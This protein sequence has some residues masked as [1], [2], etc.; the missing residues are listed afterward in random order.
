MRACT[1]PG[2]NRR[3]RAKNLCAYHYLQLRRH[4]TPTPTSPRDDVDE[5]AVERA[6]AGDVPE[7]LTTAERE[8]VVRRLNARKVP[9]LRIAAH[10]GMSSAGVRSIR[11]RLG[12]PRAV[13]PGRPRAA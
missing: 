9:D 2:C 11:L 6:I 13:P 7:H 12:L 3:H 5:I 8:E 1:V 4:G 10:L